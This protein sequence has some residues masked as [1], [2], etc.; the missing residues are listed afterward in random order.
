MQAHSLNDVG[1]VEPR[2]RRVLESTN[3]A[4]VDLRIVDRDVIVVEELRLSVNRHG[5]RLAVEHA[6]PLQDFEYVLPLM[7]KEALW[8]ALHV[9]PQKAVEKTQVLHRELLLPG[10][11]C[12]LKEGGTGR[13]EHN[14]VDI[15]QQV[16]GVSVVPEDE[17]GRVQLSFDEA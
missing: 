9:D 1:D 14:I 13:R 3:E 12:A 17:Q 7:E 16:E 15:Q 8:T 11:D 5:A 2:E 10:G 6:S 4:P